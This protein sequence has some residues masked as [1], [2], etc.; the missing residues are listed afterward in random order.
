MIGKSETMEQQS[1]HIYYTLLSLVWQVLGFA[2]PFTSQPQQTVQN[3]K[4]LC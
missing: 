4:R 1:D 2:V 3:F